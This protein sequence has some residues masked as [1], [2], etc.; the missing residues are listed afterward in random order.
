MFPFNQK[1]EIN[2]GQFVNFQDVLKH[3]FPLLTPERQKKICK[4][5]EKRNFRHAVVLE[6]IYDRGNTSAVMRSAEAFGLANIH[7]IETFDK[8]KE[9]QR[10]TAG[11]DKWL[12]IKK[13]KSTSE[14]ISYLKAQGKKIAITYLDETSVPLETLD[15][16]SQDIAI[17]MGNEKDGVSPEMVSQA[18]YKVIIPMSGFVQS[19]NI[20]VAAALCFYQ[21]E[22]SKNKKMDQDFLSLEEKEILKAH[23]A[24]R[25]LD[26]SLDILKAKLNL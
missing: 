4:V 5:V 24:M 11:A 10:T 20:S 23:Y 14:C 1:L 16:N 8:F 6:N 19:F 26:S 17:V 21:I 7:L 3:V 2:K 13:W 9:S 15:F 25:T 12:E 18:D 22:L